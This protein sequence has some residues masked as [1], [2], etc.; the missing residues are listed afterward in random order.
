MRGSSSLIVPAA[1]HK[2]SVPTACASILRPGEIAPGDGRR[3]VSAGRGVSRWTGTAVGWLAIALSIGLSARTGEAKGGG[4]P[5]A[6]G[7]PIPR[8]PATD[9]RCRDSRAG[10]T[11]WL[12]SHVPFLVTDS[13]GIHQMGQPCCRPWARAGSRWRAID[14]YGAVVGHAVVNGGEYYDVSQCHEL[15]L[16]VSSGSGGVGIF[17]SEGGGWRPPGRSLRHEASP[18]ELAQLERFVAQ[19]EQL[20]VK[21]EDF[22]SSPLRPLRERTLFFEIKERKGYF[23]VVGGHALL[24]AAWNDGRWVLLH[25]EPG[26]TQFTYR[27]LAVFDLDADGVPEI[28]FHEDAQDSW[29]DV[30]LKSSDGDGELWGR[31]AESVGGSTA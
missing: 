15:S 30:V 3:A 13:R 9:P 22:Q 31:V 26:S 24:V 19:A 5:L 20:L 11:R 2:T 7:A 18:A 25:V 8:T 16:H 29:E 21:P 14:A 4:A 17:A 27:P 23:A 10:A 6:T 12:A 1:I 28:V